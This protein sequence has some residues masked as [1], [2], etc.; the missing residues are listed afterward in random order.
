LYAWQS[1][2]TCEKLTE[3][4]IPESVMSIGSQAFYRCWKLAGVSLPEGITKINEGTFEDCTDLV[5]VTIPDRVEVIGGSAF[6]GCFRLREVILGTKVR[7][8]EVLAFQRTILPISGEEGL[9]FLT[10]DR[11]A[12]LVDSRSATGEL[13]VPGNVNGLPVE[14]VI[15]LAGNLSIT[16]VTLPEGLTTLEEFAFSGCNAL[17]EVTI[18]DSVTIL[19]AN[20]FQNSGLTSVV[21]PNGIT[22]IA[23]RTFLNCAQLTSVMFGNSVETIAAFAFERCT[24]LTR[25]EIPDAV[26][27]LEP[28]AFHFCEK[29]SEVTLGSGLES[30]GAITFR[31]TAISFE[32]DENGLRYLSNS[33]SAFLV[34]TSLGFG[35]IIVPAMFR[36]LPVRSI[37]AFS[38]NGQITAVT[39]PETISVIGD[40]AFLGSSVKNITVGENVTNIAE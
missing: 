19:G 9:S 26:R 21:I 37:N 17:T 24:S 14:S 11:S 30:I 23:E 27:Q 10:N 31:R 29:L 2:F 25:V 33:S 5:E 38:A 35:D 39:I 20:A 3:V 8:I 40:W 13:T 22:R 32:E 16:R 1:F 34:D 28:G 6:R 12:F 7:R 15:G 36:G 18:P 4:V